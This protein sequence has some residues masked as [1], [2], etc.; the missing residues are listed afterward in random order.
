MLSMIHL[1]VQVRIKSIP[2]ISNKFHTNFPIFQFFFNN[3]VLNIIKFNMTMSCFRLRA[4]D[5]VQVFWKH[6][7]FGNIS[8]LETRPLID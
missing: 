8:Q 1:I 4:G 6:K 5:H 2:F 3:D 7:C